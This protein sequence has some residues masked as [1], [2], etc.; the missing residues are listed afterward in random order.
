MV[1]GGEAGAR[2]LPAAAP[3]RRNYPPGQHGDSPRLV[4]VP[5]LR[6]QKGQGVG[7]R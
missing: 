1:S 6:L 2:I 5:S 3:G 4:V 7:S